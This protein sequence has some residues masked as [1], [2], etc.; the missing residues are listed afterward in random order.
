[1]SSDGLTSD[2][3]ACILIIITYI[4]DP[5]IFCIS[6]G[7]CK[8]YIG[9]SRNTHYPKLLNLCRSPGIQ[10][11]SNNSVAGCPCF[12][13]LLVFNYV[14]YTNKVNVCCT[15]I[16]FFFCFEFFLTTF[17]RMKRLSQMH[18]KKKINLKKYKKKY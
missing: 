1:M 10:I 13:F 14:L 17:Q 4:R 7:R 12:F 11:P 8:V 15:E 2:A 16:L 6:L 9:I 5:S 18:R 3:Y